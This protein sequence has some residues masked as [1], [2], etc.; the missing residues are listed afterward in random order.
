MQNIF[1]NDIINN[2][3]INPVI[4]RE[5]DT[6]EVLMSTFQ[7]SST[8]NTIYVV[9]ENNECVGYIDL[10]DIII[11]FIPYLSTL[12]C[13][14]FTLFVNSVLSDSNIIVI[15]PLDK[16]V[17]TET[18]Y[19]EL[20]GSILTSKT[21]EFPILNSKHEIIGEVSKKSIFNELAKFRS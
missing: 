1:V 3:S 4:V 19:D 16:Y 17:T 14:N 15:N 11:F 5:N 20:I 9:N 2:N 8:S 10:Q 7:H 6:I 12:N 18:S 21:V 13:D